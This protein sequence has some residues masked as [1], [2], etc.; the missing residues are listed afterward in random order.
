MIGESGT[1]WFH[2]DA[3][4]LPASLRGFQCGWKMTKKKK[5]KKKIRWHRQAL[6]SSSGNRAF[7]KYQA[8]MTTKTSCGPTSSALLLGS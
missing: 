8:E 7:G 2:T 3:I 6:S 4:Q 5:E 1:V